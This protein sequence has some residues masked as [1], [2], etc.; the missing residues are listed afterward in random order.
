MYVYF[1]TYSEYDY[2]C[3][4]CEKQMLEDQHYCCSDCFK[5]DML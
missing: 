5:A 4:Y 2:K 1:D 3:N